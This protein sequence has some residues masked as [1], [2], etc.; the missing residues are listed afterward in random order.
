MERKQ[1]VFF[2]VLWILGCLVAS[3]AQAFTFT[4]NVKDDAGNPVSGFRWLVEEDTTRD[5]IPPQTDLDADGYVDNPRLGI[6]NSYNPVVTKGHSAGSSATI[7]VP[8]GK[9]YY[10]SVLPD[11][12]HTLSGAPVKPGQSSV[13][14]TV[15]SHPLPTA[16]I[17]VFVFEDF[18]PINNA[19]DGNNPNN[20][21]G[22]PGLEGF[23]V[24]LF[25][26]AGEVAFDAFGNPL[27]TTY[28]KNP[29]GSFVLDPDGAPVV[30]TLGNGIV[31][32][33]D[34][35][36]VDA[37]G[38]PGIKYLVPNKYGVRAVP[39]D[40]G[41][42]WIQ[43]TTIEGT[44]TV[45]AWPQFNEPQ[46]FIEF[47]KAF[48]HVFL[49]FT[50]E[51][52]DLATL[53]NPGGL[54]GTITGRVINVHQ[55]RPPS[56]EVHEGVVV[57]DAWVGLNTQGGGATKTGVYAAP[58]DPN[59]G[60][61]SISG[62]PP[63]TYQLVFWDVHLDQIIAFRTVIVPEAG[64]AVPMGDVAVNAWFG[65]LE[66]YVF[67]D[68]D[69]DGFMDPDEVG[70]PDQA[71]NLRFRDGSIY[72]ATATNTDGFYSLLEIF[73]WFR[74]IVAEVDFARYKATGLTVVVDDGGAIPPANGWVMPSDDKR[75]PQPQ[76]AVNPN[77]GN[78]LSRTET[79]PVLTQTVSVYADQNHRIDWGKT[80]YV[81]GENGGISGIVFYDTTRAEND[82]RFNAGE[83]WQPGIPNVRVNLYRVDSF[84]G[85][86]RPKDLTLV[87]STLTDSWSDSK[88]EGCIGPAQF[89][90]LGNP[91]NPCGETLRT[92]NQVRPGVFDG[93]YAFED[94]FPGGVQTD[95]EGNPVVDANGD[96]IPVVSGEAPAPLA[97]GQFVVEVVPPP[98][99]EIVK[100]ED[101]NVDFGDVLVPAP[102]ILPPVCVGDD[103]LVPDEL[104]LFPGVEAPF[105]GQT[106]PLCDRKLV[107]NVSGR[108][109]AVDFFLFTEV[110]K[111]GRFLGIVTDDLNNTFD[112]QN[113]NFA[114]KAHVPFIPV[115]LQDYRGNE[116]NRV[117]T[118]RNG[119]YEVLVPSTFIINAPS[120]TG[121]ST[122][123]VKICLND[124]GDPANPDPF[125]NPVYQPVC[126]NFEIYPGRTRI[127]DTPVVPV[128]AFASAQTGRLDCEFP[129]GTPRIYQADGP[130]GGPYLASLPETLT[131]QSVGSSVVPNPDF[132]ATQK[133]GP[134]NPRTIIRDYGFGDVEGTV[135]LGGTPLTVTSWSSDTITVTVPAGTPTGQLEITRGDNGAST[136]VGVTVHV[137]PVASV[138]RV[139]GGFSTIQAAI[140]A[141]PPNALILVAPGTYNEQLILWKPLKLQGYGEGSTIINGMD[142]TPERE[143]VWL[144]KV[145]D[146]VAAGSVDL[147]PGQRE[148]F[149]LERGA[150]VT[151]L[152]NDGDFTEADPARIDG[153]TIF[154]V[155]AGGGGI[156][157]NAH[158][159]YLRITNNRINN[160]SGNFGGGI[161]VGWPS[162]TN[163]AG[164]AYVGS[165]NEHLLIDHNH[166]LENGSLDGGGGV[167]LY[168][169]S[170]FYQVTDNTICGNFSGLNGAGIDHFG[171]SDEG[172]IQGNR[173]TFNQVFT[174]DK[175]IAGQGG[176]ILVAG[177]PGL[178]GGMSPGSGTVVIAG[179]VIQNN[180]SAHD[181]GGIALL[182]VNGQDL[183]GPDPYA[184]GIYNNIIAK[185]VAQLAGGAL[186]LSDVV[187]ADI[188]HNT[189]AHNDSAAT[190]VEAFTLG[191]LDVTEPQVGGIAAYGHSAAVA[192]ASGA[193]FA[194]PVLD[195]NIIW[196]NRSFRW[197]V[198]LNGGLGG[199][200][201]GTE[202]VRDLEVLGAG[203][204]AA[205]DPTNCV[206]TDATGFDPSNTAADPLFVEAKFNTLL[207]A[208]SADEG[209]NSIAVLPQPLLHEGD[210]HIKGGSPAV[211]GGERSFLTPVPGA[212]V[213]SEY[214]V[215]DVDGQAR[216]NPV[217]NLADIGADEI[218][219]AF[220]DTGSGYDW[221]LGYL[222]VMALYGITK[223]CVADDPETLE[224]EA[225]FCP[226]G[227]AT[228][229]EMAAFV[230]RAR[231]GDTFTL[232]SETPYF[233]DVP[234]E[235]WAFR[236]IQKMFE[237]GLT[238]GFGDG[239]FRPENQLTRAETAAFITRSLFGETF[240]FT[241][242]PHFS[243]V[244]DSHWAFA[245]VQKM[246]DEGIANGYGD[247]TF[248]PENDITRA[249]I[250]AFI[251]RGLGLMP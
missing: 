220:N 33:A 92:W 218:Y 156:F 194:D 215:F 104:S 21:A 90:T 243:D 39:R 100:E 80:A 10:V 165:S 20:L 162:V 202:P 42:T 181:G 161:R 151:V 97:S 60:E 150:G 234:A 221:A 251:V 232:V 211:D 87:N 28:Q 179:N 167:A 131:I 98:G 216:P 241:S 119:G 53:P 12:D 197:N 27:G 145:A 184:V 79:G 163:L 177:E 123:I 68:E 3:Q 212:L 135:T 29:D 14:V 115:S 121:V 17:S 229:A 250:A 1:T 4:V 36:A 231:Y 11:A 102:E 113:P 242:T 239:T 176:G 125:F 208:N 245:Y 127:V 72:Q 6:A 114:E 160:N 219:A 168:N 207:A 61:F 116:V 118:D 32:N 236:F 140:D 65:R 170:D 130:E 89:D 153:F 88:P 91:I 86:G 22:E 204:G 203:A 49:G 192:T 8:D 132:D 30:K 109:T 117:Y 244:S 249:E 213:P 126:L 206:L 217:T 198:T 237:D 110:P 210:F 226:G 101:K 195:R 175:P 223:G 63:G 238:V 143:T 227:L 222:E 240:P 35:L 182:R 187:H 228:R 159:D 164:D 59:T 73:P 70:V 94:H 51:I 158:A 77:T 19:P 43:T 142:F 136:R 31:T 83:P 56:V 230:I 154:A 169:G 105:A 188:R 106:R 13:D 34:G 96:P 78:N 199:L 2:W 55:S 152:A 9:R 93:G 5:V 173:I 138:L 74:Y 16:Q 38:V 193:T 66:G 247:G 112:P 134:L 174:G 7:E 40:D 146:L 54:T 41:Q 233:T 209:G 67:L 64:G 185:N 186:V 103:H 139:P 23:A 26:D 15:L 128:A 180:Q 18:N 122:N 200:E 75:N 108:N 57:P 191:T 147:V 46:Y 24:K 144:A 149:F 248:R 141:A 133:E 166:I 196:N 157:V 178:A 76:A 48:W 50:H 58:A 183:L 71:V 84:D 224:N 99:Y 205:L 85:L 129:T 137:G 37:D 124:P 25:D 52:N 82:P 47:G 172:L 246:A 69:E 44:P 62:V 45:D 190:H 225:Q 81:V 107:D 95:A 155:P 201:P 235:H 171:L 214:T 148:D 111:A 189:M 120:P